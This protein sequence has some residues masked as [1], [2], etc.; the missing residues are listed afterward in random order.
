MYVDCSC[1]MLRDAEHFRSRLSKLDGAGDIGD[2][3]VGIVEQKSIERI[4]DAKP[5]AV[6]GRPIEGIVNAKGG[7]SSREEGISLANNTA[8]AVGDIGK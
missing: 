4:E 3:I 5:D 6:G 2:V 7:N 1:R 8:S